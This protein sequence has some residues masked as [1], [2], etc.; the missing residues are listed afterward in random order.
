MSLFQSIGVPTAITDQE[1]LG[2]FPDGRRA[3]LAANKAGFSVSGAGCRRTPGIGTEEQIAKR[4]P[5]QVGDAALCQV[6]G[7]VVKHMTALA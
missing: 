4:A 7:A 5:Q 3:V 2:R 1:P 6:M